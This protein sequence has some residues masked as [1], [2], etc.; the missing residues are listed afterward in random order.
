MKI[1]LV[2][3]T[4]L[5]LSIFLINSVNA[6]GVSS[7]YT[8]DS[9][10]TVYPGETKNAQLTL[11]PGI[12]GKDVVVT[13][14]ILDNAGIASL[15]DKNLK[16]LVSLE[17]PAIVNIKLKMPRD[18]VIGEEYAIKLRFTDVTPSEKEEMVGFKQ[19]SIIF[20]KAGV[21]EKPPEE[22]IGIVWVVLLLVLIVIVLVIIWFVIRSRKSKEIRKI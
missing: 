19:G 12:D 17:E 1:F 7:G 21:V 9:P 6:F 4:G 16:Y 8:S 14:E 3:V 11:L 18:A 20:L 10:L 22:K 15:I 13:A 5:L 2:F